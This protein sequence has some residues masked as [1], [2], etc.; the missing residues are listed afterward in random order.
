MLEIVLIGL[1]IFSIVKIILFIKLSDLFLVKHTKRNKDKLIEI[2]DDTQ[3]DDARKYKR[4][5]FK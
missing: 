5:Y 3:L 4:D 2:N 1:A